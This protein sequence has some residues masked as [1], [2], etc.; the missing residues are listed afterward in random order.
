M[1]DEH[2]RQVRFIAIA[3][4]GAI[5]A[6]IAVPIVASGF[7][8]RPSP[9]AT[10][11]T[12]DETRAPDPPM[13]AEPRPK[14]LSEAPTQFP[15]ALPRSLTTATVDD[16][17]VTD[18]ATR[19]GIPVPAMRAYATAA[20]RQQSE[21]PQ[22]GLGW[23][24][25]A[26]IG[27]IETHHGTIDG[28]TL[29]AD[30]KALPRIVGIPL[31]GDNVEAIRDTDLGLLDGDTQWDRAIGPM[32]FIPQTWANWSI[33]ADGDGRADPDDFD[34][35]AATAAR[36]LCA[37]GHD[38]ATHDGWISAVG[39]YNHHEDYVRSVAEE[40]NRLAACLASA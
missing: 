35:T 16:A 20:V 12:A 26:A 10:S 13:S 32:Q 27:S 24:T 19:T 15:T 14:H 21:T 23:T 39:S 30:G 4:G 22:C 5:V 34:D 37:D 18:R 36:Y 33:D 40:A 2:A 7:T 17:W 31:N 3:A 29:T 25:L 38:L 1:T 9:S 8:Y 28:R 6:A 11:A